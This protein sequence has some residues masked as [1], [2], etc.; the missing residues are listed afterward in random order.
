[1]FIMFNKSSAEFSLKQASAIHSAVVTT[2]KNL[3][4]TLTTHSDVPKNHY[5]GDLSYF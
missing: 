5:Q 4:P 3:T 1:M 2:A